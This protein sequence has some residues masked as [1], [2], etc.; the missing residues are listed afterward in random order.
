MIGSGS[1][2]M[3][4]L[5]KRAVAWSVMHPNGPTFDYDVA[6]ARV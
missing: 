4:N 5:E 2:N 3:K 1:E 6:I